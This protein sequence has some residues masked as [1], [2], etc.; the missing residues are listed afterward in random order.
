VANRKKPE[1]ERVVVSKGTTNE[2]G[3]ATGAKRS[4][5]DV[6]VNSNRSLFGR[7]TAPEAAKAAEE[8]PATHADFI[9]TLGVFR[10]DLNAAQV[11]HNLRKSIE[12][13]LQAL[14][15]ETKKSKP[16]LAMIEEK[17]KSIEGKIKRAAGSG[18]SLVQ[19]AAQLGKLARYLFRG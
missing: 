5:C 8:S 7:E 19:S 1:Q 17:L 11:A 14:D 9:R 10:E 2:G 4:R 3:P 13:D 15:D 18:S 6:S 16:S 12:V